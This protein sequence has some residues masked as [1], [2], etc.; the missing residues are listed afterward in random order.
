MS[1]KDA[2][3][4]ISTDGGTPTLSTIFLD[5]SEVAHKIVSFLPAKDVLG[6]HIVNQ[7]CHNLISK[8]EDVLFEDF[9]RRDFAE[10][11]VL[12]Y[13]A[14]E[15][16][17]SK[18]YLYLAFLNRRSLPKLEVDGTC[19]PHGYTKRVCV[20]WQRPSQLETKDED[21]KDYEFPEYSDDEDHA[22]GPLR[23]VSQ[24]EDIAAV[25]FIAR[26]G[27]DDDPN[28][29][30]LMDW[31]YYGTMC[32][33]LGKTLVLDF[34]RNEAI[35]E[36][37]CFY[38][39]DT[40]KAENILEMAT[41]DEDDDWYD[42]LEKS[43]K[44][45]HRMT[46]HAVNIRDFQVMSLMDE[47][48]FD[49]PLDF[50]GGSMHFNYGHDSLPN[51]YGVPPKTSPYYR[52]LSDRDYPISSYEK[53]ISIETFEVTAGLELSFFPYTKQG[54]KREADNVDDSNR[55]FCRKNT[56]IKLIVG[57]IGK[58]DGLCFHFQ[59]FNKSAISICSFLRALMNDKCV[60]VGGQIPSMDGK[61]DR[62]VATGEYS[63]SPL[64]I[65]GKE[66]SLTQPSSDN[67]EFFV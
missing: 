57:N 12:A 36:L 5:V 16:R 19:G 23:P 51:L 62:Y 14:N 13:I 41:D 6:M 65:D 58:N 7:A 43:W 49:S 18:K 31:E 44:E 38:L 21:D 1:K 27:N 22:E 32:N 24:N 28:T 54:D 59:R 8:R 55:T 63:R 47:T 46:L 11:N 15:R 53:D 39:P 35:T 30:A 34:H 25:V 17:V 42:T 10:G 66:A 33:E 52:E 29:C 26:V 4:N 48:P 45:T 3:D 2:V 67:T 56:G 40:S 61:E 60:V 9:I 20:D 37:G 50:S 64:L